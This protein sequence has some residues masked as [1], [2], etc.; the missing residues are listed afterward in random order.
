MDEVSP[1]SDADKER[2]LQLL[3]GTPNRG[4]GTQDAALQ[5]AELIEHEQ[6]VVAG[7]LVMAVPDAHLL[8]AMRRADA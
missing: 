6:R 7:A 1:T 2:N 3:A 5:I 8:L 4:A